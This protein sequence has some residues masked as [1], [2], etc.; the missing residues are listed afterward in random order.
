MSTSKALSRWFCS[1]SWFPLVKKSSDMILGSFGFNCK[2]LSMASSACTYTINKKILLHLNSYFDMA[3][4]NCGL[5]DVD[6]FQFLY[7]S[8]IKIC[9]IWKGL[10]LTGDTNENV[11]LNFHYIL[12]IP[13]SFCPFI[14]RKNNILFASPF[15]F[16][17]QKLSA[18]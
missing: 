10:K 17:P 3:F 12:L 5:P 15:L 16:W 9:H 13:L 18:S 6:R 7:T 11:L 1:L 4:S 14:I 8:T 2:A